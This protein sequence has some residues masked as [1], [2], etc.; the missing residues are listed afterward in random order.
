MSSFLS[1]MLVCAAIG[2]EPLDFGRDGWPVLDSD[3]GRILCDA[4]GWPVNVR[5]DD[6]PLLGDRDTVNQGHAEALDASLA[7]RYATERGE[8]IVSMTPLPALGERAWLRSL[9]YRNTS[10]AVQDLTQAVFRLAP[11][12]EDSRPA[13]Q[14]KNFF[15]SAAAGERVLAIAY[16][17]TTD[18]YHLDVLDGIV[19]HTVDAAWRLGPGKVATIESQGVWLTDCFRED[20]AE[21]HDWAV[22]FRE[23]ARR[24]YEA[25]G[26]GI[27]KGMPSWVPGM[28]LY[29][30]SAG[31]HVD[32]RFS[33]VGGFRHLAR[34]VDYLAEMGV[35]AVWLQAVHTHKAPPNPMEGRWNLYGPLDVLTVDPI[36]GGEAGLEELLADLHAADIRVL[37]EIVPHGGRS[38]QGEALP[39][40]WTRERDGSHRSNWNGWAI[41]HASPPWQAMMAKAMGRK[42]RDFGIVGCRIDVADGNGSN[43]GSPLTNHASFSTLGGAVQL[44]TRV[45]DAMAEHTPYPVL[46]PEAFDQV[47]YFPMA[48][49]GYGHDFWMFIRNEIEPVITEPETMAGL[50]RDYLERERGSLPP[51]AL[52]LRTLNNHDTV[53]RGGRVTRRFGVGLSRALHGVCLVIPGVPM[54]YQEQEIGSWFA[55]R[56]MHQAR[57]AIPAFASEEVDYLG[58]SFSPEVFAVLRGNAETGLAIGLVNLS[59]TEIDGEARL[60]PSALFPVDALPDGAV[61]VDALTGAQAVVTDR[62]FPW[63]L[64]PYAA[65]FLQV[66]PAVNAS[67]PPK[68]WRV[69]EQRPLSDGET[70][71]LSLV[72]GRLVMD[73]GAMQVEILSGR[74]KWLLH[75]ADD[76]TQQYASGAVELQVTPTETGLRCELVFPEADPG[77]WPAIEL[78]GADA[79]MVAGRT[80]LLHDRALRRHFPWPEDVDYTWD[81]TMFWGPHPGGTTYDRISPTGRM[82]ESVFEPLHPEHPAIGFHDSGGEGVLLAEIATDCGNLLLS[83]TATADSPVLRLAFRGYDSEVAAHIN[84]GSP[85]APYRLEHPEPEPAR[86]YHTSFTLSMRKEMPAVIKDW[87]AAAEPY[88][89]DRPIHRRRFEGKGTHL[90]PQVGIVLPEP[91]AVIWEGLVFPTGHRTVRLTLRHSEQS[92]EGTDLDAAYRILVNDEELPVTWMQRN[93]SQHRNA[94]FGYADI[95]LPVASEEV[96][97]LRI[98]TTRNWGIV[99]EIFVLRP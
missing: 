39:E 83:E 8:L 59:G 99:K 74:E 20:V 2:V 70:P 54:L 72:D 43:W 86:R 45:R 89:M 94:Y 13:W 24:W 22:R 18:F 65:A 96:Y 93:V 44:L 35:N 42:A 4:E 16:Q 6:V 60:D 48:A 5:V 31:G 80:A 47:E 38:V 57:H 1:L 33:D 66:E 17:G 95:A 81:K 21:E 87:A 50:L 28:I 75:A 3:E 25:I 91:G 58:V 7:Y 41:D 19:E 37:G 67:A 73:S 79:W 62:R 77:A 36:L 9:T 84:L 61:I 52:T 51:G 97:T 11:V 34:Q 85:C 26:I 88:P 32:A 10:D 12:R 76:A 71:V 15:M 64:P 40:W 69:D 63:R 14:P 46:I 29:E 56:D 23:Q 55:L 68:H 82:W 92:P 30:F 53:V 49:V 78:T 98:E 27:P 90:L